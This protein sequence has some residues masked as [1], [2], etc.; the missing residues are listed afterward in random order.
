M[1]FFFVGLVDSIL[2]FFL[3]FAYYWK[4]SGGDIAALVA[5][6]LLCVAHFLVLSITLSLRTK[7]PIV[8]N[9]LFGTFLGLITSFAVYKG[10]DS[11]R[12]ATFKQPAEP[13]SVPV[14]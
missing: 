2:L 3:S 1:R 13:I 11:Y 14:K 12:T 10:I 8:R 6:T 4:E 7:A 9:L 5:G